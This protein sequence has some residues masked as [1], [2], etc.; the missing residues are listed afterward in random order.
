MSRG[1]KRIAWILGGGTA[2]LLLLAA[3]TVIIVQSQWFY[4]RVRGRLVETV[5]TATG[6]R[7]EIGS[8]QFDWRR[9][10]AEVHAFTLHG[11]EP[12]DKPPLFRA[13]SV[14]VGL[15]IVS[16]LKRDVDISYLD[17]TAPQV[18]LIVGPDGRTNVPEPKV[19]KKA[20]KPAIQTILDLAIGRFSLERGQ[21]E[22]ASGGKT[23]FSA[24]GHNLN[25][26]F[27]YDL[28]GPRYRGNISIQPLDLQL[29]SYR[30][31]PVGISTSLTI[32][33]NRIAVNSAHLMAGAS[34][35][36]FSGAIEN[37]ASPN[38]TFQFDAGISVD[39][40]TPILRIP[41]L[42]H[43][44]MQLRG[45]A[46]WRSASDFL[47]AGTLHGT[48]LAYRDPSIR[49]EGF[50]ADGSLTVNPKGVDVG[51]LRLNGSYV[52]DIGRAPVD[53]H[54][55]AVTLRGKD[56]QLAGMD[57]A[58]FGGRFQGEGKV[59]DLIRYSAI[60]TIAGIEVRPVVAMYS[61]EHLPWNA[62]AS[63]P[64][65]VEGSFQRAS[66]LR[67]SATLTVAPAGDSAPVH[68]QIDVA[69]LARDRTVGLGHSTVTLPSSR[70]DFSGTLGRQL[71][72]HLD[73]RNLDDL[74][75]AIGESAAALPAKLTGTAIFDG[76]V[77][78]T[79]DNPQISGHTRVTGILFEGE[80][81]D[82]L[83][84]DAEVS[85]AG[86]RM[87][88]GAVTQGQLR[89][90][91]QIAVGLDDWKS[92]DDSPLSGSGTLR[93]GTVDELDRVLELKDIPVT[94]DAA[95]TAQISGTIGD[96]HV[97]ADFQLTH[98][99]L[100]DE[101]FDRFTGHLNYNASLIELTGGQLNA[102]NGQAS[103]NGAYR[104][105]P[106]HFD[107]GHLQ[108]RVSTNARSL[109]QIRTLRNA[110][111]GLKGT[112]Q[113]TAD[114]E[115]DI[116]PPRAGSDTPTFRLTALNAD[117]GG[118]NLQISEQALGDAH[119]TVSSQ[120]NVLR[121][122][123]E[124][125]AANSDVRGDGEWRLEGDYPGSA[126][127]T[128]GKLDLAQLRAWLEPKAAVSPGPFIGSAEG[129]LRIDGPLLQL[130]ALKAE[131]RIPKFEFG[132]APDST[133]PVGK[134]VLHN[135]GP[136]VVSMVNNVITVDS[137]HLTGVATDFSI[138]G[139]VS[140]QQKSP[141][142]LRATGRL[143]LALLHDFNRDFTSSGSVAV[144]LAV[145]G[146]LD[147]PQVNGHT[148]FQK[149]AFSIEG[150]P[151]GISN[152]NGVVA[153]T[154]DK[155]N[156]A[157][158]T[159][160]SFSGETGGGKVELTG[161]A[162]YNGGPAIF[163]VRARATQV[164]IRYPEG[165]STVVNANLTLTGSE[166]RS[167]LDG[168]LTI[169]RTGF[170]P[171]SDFSSL[172]GKSAEPVQT[173]AARTGLLGGLNFDIQINTTPDVQFQSSLTQD[174]QMEANLRLRGT[175][176]NPAVLGRINITQ[177]QLIFFGTKY[178]VTQGT[179]QFF[180]PVRIDPI[181][182]IDLETKANGIDVTLN[183]SGPFTKPNL[184]PRSD[185]PLQFNEIVALLA[186]G[187]S[188]TSDPTRLAQESTAPQSWQQMGASALLG[189]A[190]A[191]PVTGR[192]QRFFGV[193]QLRI[194]PTLPGVE[195]NPQARLT[196]EQQV[197][198]DITFTY[199]TDVTNSNPQVVR[200]EWSF[201]RQWSVVALRE[202]NGLFGIDFF[203]KKRF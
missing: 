196:L 134:L 77:S 64:V 163:R 18:Y 109:E 24:S 108:L 45:N 105:A 140:F 187:R 60:G 190:L 107:T 39:E 116:A 146:P 49:L 42:H 92:G 119:L 83:E 127:I 157:R 164:R 37:L 112:V 193:S 9:L 111:P 8:F 79:I 166:D 94:G 141:L 99:A 30:P 130:Q 147:A 28:A 139:K 56:L 73:T 82:S 2:L 100:R 89:A 123:L 192:L 150:V 110:F 175:F 65:D 98:G 162:G 1:R 66:E 149:A 25:A 133:L 177:G 145:R 178:T 103:V 197:T 104:H 138:T 183:V 57:L 76:T 90:Q 55:A 23:P 195:S 102:G 41:E 38:G 186:T 36:V 12:A 59:L 189:Q 159:I 121:A 101:P 29:G 125:N 86:V 22:V 74:L 161:F 33:A 96:P 52:T 122:H 11:T 135:A 6:G 51:G 48:D 72:V 80:N 173:P 3:A 63:G 153:F 194:D 27:L 32:E 95:G 114:G 14:A 21:F 165:V 16:L 19:A 93:G 26:R 62:L 181:L 129:E 142:D 47:V 144:D 202:D 35:V 4:H 172:L 75:P 40:T 91:F 131:L 71:R 54:I 182:D 68:G 156:G 132:P 31:M 78:G 5:E 203:F 13:E 136:I 174:V 128:L 10:R 46:T 88:N 87:R 120:G 97:A 126:T 148:E 170:N 117:I 199:I 34:N 118:H 84:G 169:V 185:P 115:L 167:N 176:S 158:A 61:K 20:G 7:V 85:P 184:T 67:A 191:S 154:D 143:D 113:V 188:P 106:G 201:A 58:V 155:T 168:T 50:R 198:S 180:N 17:V 43:G 152:A 44:T 15:K 151:N 81:F 137:A 200:M 124:S 160:Q 53:G 171:Q 179:V 70:V 69:Y